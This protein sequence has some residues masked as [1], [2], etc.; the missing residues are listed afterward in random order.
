MNILVINAGSSSIK[1]K[2]YDMAAPAER[3]SGLVERMGEVEANII[4]QVNAEETRLSERIPDADRGVARLIELLTTVGNPPPLSAADEVTGIGHRVVHG[5]EAFSESVLVDDRVLAAIDGCSSLAPLHNPANLAGLRAAMKI[6]AGKPHVAVFDT[7]FFQTMPPAAYHYALPYEWY[8][9]HRV[10]RYGFHGTSH[11]YVTGRATELLGKPEPNLITL[12]LGNGCSMACI[13]GGRAVDQT[14]GLTPLEGLVMGTRS[15]DID[16]AIVF[17]MLRQGLSVDEVRTA[18]EK[19][20]GLLGLSGVARD[21]RDVHEAAEAG[22]ARAA[23]AIDVFAHRVRKYIGAF[24]A[25]LGTCDA[26]VFT[27]GIGENAVF[28]R[29][30]ILAGLAPLGIEL[31]AVRNDHR[32]TEPFCISS[33]ASRTTAWVIPTDEELMIARDTAQLIA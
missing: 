2:L 14:M 17:H 12:H 29:E 30:K 22:N 10:R 18:L 20:S 27:G 24:L 6:L 1:Y 21:L 8:E 5:G 28:M 4:H 19:K 9:K 32:G 31:D 25:E 15:G 23:L 13:R 7:A 33:D 11:R 3:A 26:L 16:P